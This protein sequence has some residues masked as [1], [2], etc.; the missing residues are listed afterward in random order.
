MKCFGASF[1]LTIFLSC[2]FSKIQAQTSSISGVINN[3]VSV[4][5][6]GTQS[7]NV[8]S[9]VGFAVG[10]RVLLIQMKGALIDT[11]NTSNFGTILSYNDA[12]NY[13]LLTISAINS[14]NV[15]FTSS[16]L[17]TYN[18]NGIVQLIKVPVYNNVLVTSSLTCMPW[19]GSIGGVLAFETTGNVT[20]NASVDVTGKGFSGGLKVVGVYLSCLGN[21]TDFKLPTSSMISAF[22][23]EGIVITN[24]TFSKGLGA[25]ANGGG[26]GNDVNGGGAGGG[27]FGMG[28]RGGDTK[29]SGPGIAICGGMNAKSC[30]YSN[31]TNKIFLGGGGGAGHE[32]DNVGTGG[33]SGG[34]IVL[35]K[36]CS[37][38]SNGFDI[39]ANGTDNTLIAGNDGQGGGGAGGTVL[40]DVGSTSVLTVSVKGGFGGVDSY[41]GASCH[42][43]GGGGGGGT[44]WTSQSSISFNSI[45]TGGLPGVF[46]S[47]SSPCFNT[48]NGATAGQIG[49]TL[50]GLVIPGSI[51]TST[52]SINSICINNNGTAVASLST[53]ILN[54][55]VSYTWTNASNTTVSLTNNSSS[56]SNTVT[57]L[58]N[59]TYT[60]ITQINAPCGPINSQTVNINCVITPT[61][62]PLCSGTLGPPIFTEDFGSGASI[63]GPPLGVGITN[64]P[65]QMGVP[66]NGT[67]VIANSSN[68]SGTNA[69]YVNDR[70][71][72]GNTNGYMMVVNS[73]YAATE[74][75]RKQI[76]GL[77]QNTTYVFS[78]YLANNNSPD[79]VTNVCG[80]SYVYANIKFQVEFPIGTIQNSITSGS[81][82]VATNSTTLPWIQ[83]GFAFTTGTG[84]TSI[85]IVL[86]NNA[87]GGCGNDYVVDDVS[88][89]MCGPGVGLSIST[90]NTV[91]CPGESLTLQSTFT[92]GGYTNPQYQWQFSS[93]GGITW[94]NISGANSQNYNINSVNLTQIGLYQLIVAENGNINS[95]SCSTIVG[96]ITFSLSNGVP[97]N[98]FVLPNVFTP[99]G[100]GIN[101]LIDFSKYSACATAYEFEIFDRWG[102]SILKS[103]ETKQTYWDGRTTSGIEVSDGTY[104][105][106]LKTNSNSYRGIISVFR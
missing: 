97:S 82:A 101:D 9:A 66:S 1:F 45:I 105:Y 98:Q 43:K 7:V 39:N 55:I 28:G 104:F 41:V 57:N 88:L 44:I 50:T 75:Y 33:V 77:C 96:P 54:P 24:S 65:Y 30:A 60:L 8:V 80:P 20:L 74:V 56:L 14:T 13:E 5:T 61:I 91:F 71:H 37:I 99:N 49:G 70:D 3:Y 79:A 16:L 103:T 42:G 93:N 90:N 29:C 12:G 47:G 62:P 67:Y 63:Y 26:A 19:N 83:Y 31:S 27:N 2:C 21:S 89:S 34:G 23:G 4:S 95:P 81:L 58:S 53:S 17:R 87:P 76:T 78:A 84:Q 32:N 35:I 25:L 68:P 86:I 38:L 106:I 52:L 72:T 73:D 94:S 85:D 102:L 22:K 36:A 46:T 59:G 64:Y 18:V 11:T 6:I 100:D 51:L 69:G 10:D 48:S 40:L 92:S 15:T